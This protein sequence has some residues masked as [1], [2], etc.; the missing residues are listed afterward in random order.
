MKRIFKGAMAIGLVASMTACTAQ[1]PPAAT[2]AAATEA[3]TTAVAETTEAAAAGSFVA[4]TYSGS[5]QGFGGKVTVTITTTD[6]EITDVQ[7]EGKDETPTVGGAALEE[8]AS[9]VKTAQSSEIDG[10][11]GAT[12]TS[13][14]V[15]AAAAKAI[16]AAQKGEATVANDAPLAFTAGT[17]TGKGTGYNGEVTVDVTFDDKSVTAIEVKDSKETDQVGTPAFDIVINDIIAANGTGVDS[18]SGATFSSRAIKEAVNDAADQ[19]GVT[20]K[21]AFTNNAIEVKAQDTIEETYDVVVV[22]AGGAGI[23]AAAQAAQDGNTVLVIEKNAQVGG[24][25]L[26]SGGQYQSVMPYLVWDEKNPDATTGKGFDGKEYN[27]V[28]SVKGCID[29]LKVIL[30]WSEDEFDADYYNDH[31][32]V[33][34]DI[35][36]LSKHGVVKDYLPTL[37]ALKKE[38]QAYLDWAQPKL[39]A[40]T[41]ESDL[42]LFSTLNLH[43]F[44]TYYGGLRQSADKSSWIYGDVDL[45]TQFITDGQDIKPWLESMGST[46]V[47]DTQPTLIGALWYRENQFI[48]ANVD[49]DGDGKTE[50]YGGRWG[51]YFMAPMTA[52][53]NANEANKIM[54]RTNAEELI[55]EDGRVTG[56][57][58]TMYDGTPV[59]AHATKGVILS[60]GGFAANIA[61]VVETNEYWSSEYLNDKLET[62][63]RSSLQGDGI[64]MA[65]AAGAATT[66]EGFTQLMPISW[67]DDG[68]LAFGGGDYAI[69]INPTTGNRFV[70]ETSERDVLSLGEFKNG[71]EWKGHKG[72]FIE[73]ANAAVPIP[74]P[75][76]YKDEDVEGRQYVRTIGELA[77]L[78][79]EIGFDT[80]ADAVI[81]T[82]KD[83]DQAIMSGT[84]P[85][86][87]TKKQFSALIGDAE[88]NDDGSYKAD[89]YNLDDAKLRVR[90]LA[91]STHHTM[92][93]I[94]VD[95]DRHVLDKDGKV[96]PGLYAAGE[97]TGGIHGGNRLG[98]NAITEIFVS[99]RTAAKAA[100]ADNK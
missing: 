33:A 41:P 66:G 46:F 94:K 21:D 53:K 85:K 2:T 98:G 72:V 38:I 14:A 82:I 22:G 9:Q 47:E 83:Y 50:E 35:E 96:I 8:L 51:T 75:Y 28:K 3:A 39:D 42:T 48:G 45:V 34:G 84:Q 49:A 81:E 93:G 76:P 16:E 100:T 62:T 70:D 40:G 24:N 31:E 57:K 54:T 87:V 78:F 55:V 23:S 95:V 12:V 63:N 59:V 73:I 64:K 79:K 92:G 65:E 44:Q 5:E 52:F 90:L 26:V 4:G 67:V 29:E 27:K 71:I 19:A 61:K 97:V 69:Y 11:S 88:K 68:D 25:T 36:E 56:V 20:N 30:N 86:D 13:T 43:I 32:Y 10:V 7:I 37:Q 15:K 80:D 77:D 1:Q 60:T 99:G 18:V 6:S 17:Y 89:T 58:A 74:G 91:P